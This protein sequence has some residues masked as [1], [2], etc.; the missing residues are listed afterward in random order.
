LATALL[1]VLGA[2][3]WWRASVWADPAALWREASVRAQAIAPGDERI[4]GAALAI[5]LALPVTQESSR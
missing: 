1:L 4:H 3:C 5:S 2:L